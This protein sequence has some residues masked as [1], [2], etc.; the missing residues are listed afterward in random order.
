MTMDGTVAPRRKQTNM[1]WLFHQAALGDWVLTFPLLRRLTGP[2]MAVTS[3]S[4][5][6]LAASMFEHVQAVDIESC[7]F[8]RLHRPE[9]RR[10]FADAAVIIS[11][12]SD[13]HDT[14]AQAV[15]CVA[16]SARCHFVSP[17]PA[18]NWR[19]H[20]CQ[21]HE[22][23]LTEQGLVL[24][25][26]PR[27]L[28]QS[29]DVAGALVIHLGS[30]GQNKCWPLERFESVV[31]ALRA[32]GH[33]VR[34]VIG[35]VELD[36]WPRAVLKHWQ[37]EHDA[38]VLNSLG[39]L[40]KVLSDASGFIGNDAGPTHL[41]AQMGLETIALFGPTEPRQWSPQGPRVTVLAPPSPQPMTWLAPSV[42][43]AACNRIGLR[44]A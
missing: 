33:Q 43:V 2:V 16:G 31:T 40:Y 12:V 1:T 37:S 32:A 23:Q 41:A 17:R 36:R 39:D 6:Q 25:S 18:A 8:T 38:Q 44:P 22:Q 26:G 30:G 34:V 10:L 42:V 29:G 4:K 27:D 7:T 28:G 20:I 3:W 24:G 21:W 19:G 5:A 9:D 13:G 35:E 15:K 11:F 14:W